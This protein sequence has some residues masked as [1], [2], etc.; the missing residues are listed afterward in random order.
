VL[1]T[2][3]ANRN[4]T[5]VNPL[6]TGVSRLPDTLGLDPRPAAGSPAFANAR[7]TPAN[8]LYTP[9]AYQGAF[10]TGN[11]LLDWTALSRNCY[12]TAAGAEA[13]KELPYVEAA[14][15]TADGGA[16]ATVT[17]PSA[18]GRQYKVQSSTD[19]A[20]WTDES[21]WLAGTGN[22]LSVNSSVPGVRKLF[23]VLV[24]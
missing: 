4:F 24:R 19:L 15:T 7:P 1:F 8:G 9:A 12:A 18:A 2:T 10:G 6:L 14:V 13:K 22:A 23:R 21:V 16:T 17:W 11:W 20:V 3:A 5:N